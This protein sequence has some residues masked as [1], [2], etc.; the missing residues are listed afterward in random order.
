M[1]SPRDIILTGKL[2]INTVSNHK[3]TKAQKD[4][5]LLASED[6][7]FCVR[8]DIRVSNSLVEKGLAKFTTGFGWRH[9]RLI[10]LTSE[11]KLVRGKLLK[12]SKEQ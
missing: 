5:I 3:L 4:A 10:E 7:D 8:P 12:A 6:R 9:G 11:G 1:D 2:S